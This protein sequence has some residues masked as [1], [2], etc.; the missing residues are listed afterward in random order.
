MMQKTLVS[1]NVFYFVLH[2]QI[3]LIYVLHHFCLNFL[4]FH[5]VLQ[6]FLIAMDRDDR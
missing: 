1:T 2:L 3:F 6:G 4:V 5:L